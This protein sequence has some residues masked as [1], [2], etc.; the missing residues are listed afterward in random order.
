MELGV[1][2]GVK[3]FIENSDA[4]NRLWF[5]QK[6]VRNIEFTKIKKRLRNKNFRMSE[7]LLKAGY[8]I[9]NREQFDQEFIAICMNHRLI[10]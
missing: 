3:I 10:R 1:I 9:P 5:Y 6:I 2:Q 7:V 4:E 8:E